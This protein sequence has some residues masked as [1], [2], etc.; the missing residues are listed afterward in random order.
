MKEENR[1]FIVKDKRTIWLKLQQRIGS[2]RCLV[3][4]RDVLWYH[5]GTTLLYSVE[6]GSALFSM[7]GRGFKGTIGVCMGGSREK[8]GILERKWAA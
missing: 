2:Y 7:M 8:H 1:E 6:R 5:R 4:Q 3:H